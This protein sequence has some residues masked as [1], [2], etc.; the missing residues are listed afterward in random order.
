VTA[1]EQINE[2]AKERQAIWREMGRR[3]RE[4]LPVDAL[5][6]LRLRVWQIEGKLSQLWEARRRGQ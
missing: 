3:I 6:A 2:L 5:G 1:L 4:D